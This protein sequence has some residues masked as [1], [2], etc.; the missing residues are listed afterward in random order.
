MNIFTSYSTQK[1]FRSK[2]FTNGFISP[3]L[4]GKDEKLFYSRSTNGSIMTLVWLY[5]LSLCAR[6]I[7]FFPMLIFRSVVF[8]AQKTS[9]FWKSTLLPQREVYHF[10]ITTSWLTYSSTRDILSYS[11]FV[12]RECPIGILL[13]LLPLCRRSHFKLILEL[14]MLSL[15]QSHFRH[16]YQKAFQHHSLII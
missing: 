16:V 6:S 1:P 7:N 13:Y 12:F 11:S 9:I 10:L 8:K 2:A 15:L 4:I 5:T 3:C 14:P